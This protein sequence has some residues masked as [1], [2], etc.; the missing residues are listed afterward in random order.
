MARLESLKQRITDL[1]PYDV[2]EVLVLSI[3]GG[4]QAYLA[5]LRESTAQG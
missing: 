2:P 3:A 1:H 4:S 5:W